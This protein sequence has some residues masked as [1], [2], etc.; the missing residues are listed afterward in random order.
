MSPQNKKTP[1]IV[2]RAEH[3]HFPEIGFFDVPARIDTGAKNSAIWA[4][5]ISEEDGVLSYRLF[6][7]RSPLYTG[8]QYT[9]VDYEPVIIAS[10]TGVTQMRYK[11]KLLVRLKGKKIRATFTL[12]NRETQAFPVLVGRN[13]LLGKFLV[14]V[15]KVRKELREIKRRRPEGLNSQL[16]DLI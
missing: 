13:V 4:S 16:Q 11:V 10:S 2:G 6:D 14:D 8:E 12:A 7:T 9:T 15:K 3:V 5:R 1:K